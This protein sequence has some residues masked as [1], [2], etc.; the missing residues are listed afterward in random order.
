MALAFT[1]IFHIHR[2]MTMYRSICFC[3]VSTRPIPPPHPRPYRHTVI[4]ESSPQP[5]DYSRFSHD[6]TKI[7][8]NELSILLSFYLHK[9]LQHL[10]PLFK[11]I[12]GLKG[13]F[14]L[15]QRRLQISR[16]LREKKELWVKNVADFVRFFYHNIPHLGMNVTLIYMSSLNDEF[17]HLQENSKTDVSVGFRQPYLCPSKGHRHGMIHCVSCLIDNFS[18]AFF[19]SDETLHLVFDQVLLVVGSWLKHCV[20]CLIYLIST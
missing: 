9:A 5:S 15:Q 3:Y 17:T 18:F 12:F 6:V 10:T 4:S 8:T 11:Q 2:L 14:V 19:K 7:Q 16:L 13:Y 20:S 1:V